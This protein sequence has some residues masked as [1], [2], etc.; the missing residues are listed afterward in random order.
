ML[1]GPLAWVLLQGRP[2]D[3]TDG[4]AHIWGVNTHDPPQCSSF[5]ELFKA[6]EQQRVIKGITPVFLHAVV[7]KYNFGD[8][9]WFPI[10]HEINNMYKFLF[11]NLIKTGM[12]QC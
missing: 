2:T 8:L 11:Y 3:H 9:N 10:K 5:S 6:S 4:L 1:P 7:F 12:K